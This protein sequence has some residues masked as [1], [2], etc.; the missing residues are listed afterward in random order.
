LNFIKVLIF[1]IV[2]NMVGIGC[3][4]P[5]PD[6]DSDFVPPCSS[7]ELKCSE[8]QSQIL[9]CLEN[10]EGKKVFTP[11]KVCWDGTVCVQDFC[12]P[13]PEESCQFQ[14]DCQGDDICTAVVGSSGRIDN[15]CIPSPVPDGREVG[16]ACSDHDQ[17]Y[18]GWCFR[19]TCYT[20]CVEDSDCPFSEDC[21]V[22]S[23]TIDSIKGSVRGCVLD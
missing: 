16:K 20:P 18:S 10:D 14:A 7:G 8:D 1:T 13:A 15:F 3:T 2:V 4:E 23:I 19:R 9:V 22:L 6:Y 21:V 17:C 12:E 5:N 11:D